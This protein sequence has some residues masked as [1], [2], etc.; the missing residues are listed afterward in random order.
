MFSF[1]YFLSKPPLERPFFFFVARPSTGF[2]LPLSGRRDDLDFFSFF[3]P[4][5]QE[6]E[7]VAALVLEVISPY[8]LN[9]FSRDFVPSSVLSPIA[10][11]GN[12]TFSSC[13]QACQWIARILSSTP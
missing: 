3:R 2:L 10:L 8:Q 9:G 6:S 12:F 1:R 4:L 5:S 11:P 7:R 13:L